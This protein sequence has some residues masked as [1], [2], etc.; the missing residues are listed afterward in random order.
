MI[1]VI[2]LTVSQTSRDIIESRR[3]GAETFIVKP[4]DFQN[5]SHVTPDLQMEWALF[6]R[7][8]GNRPTTPGAP[9]SISGRPVTFIERL[10][11]TRPY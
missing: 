9:L 6:K 2:V 8:P 4:V 7:G 1:P 3:L 5:F 11:P 10:A